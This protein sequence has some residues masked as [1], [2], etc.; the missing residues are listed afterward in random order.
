[1]KQL[2]VA[3]ALIITATPL[4]AADVNVSLSVGQP[5]FYGQID[6]GDHPQPRVLYRQP[7]MVERVEM[8]RP[9]IYMR[10]PPGHAQNWR[11]HC[12]EYNACGERVYFVQ[13]NWYRHEYMPRYRDRHQDYRD[14]DRNNRHDR[15]NDDR[16]RGRNR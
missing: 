7:R 6:M 15:R 16:G 9:P 13:D 3:A 1:M 10:V 8:D 5:G 12:R 2:L 11:R 14:D 4:F